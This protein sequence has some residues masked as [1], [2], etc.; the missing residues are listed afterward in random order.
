MAESQIITQF[1]KEAS[2]GSFKIS[3]KGLREEGK[4]I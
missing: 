1:P 3:T 2:N 4:T